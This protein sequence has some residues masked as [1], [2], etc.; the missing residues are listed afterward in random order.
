MLDRHLFGQENA[1][2]VKRLLFFLSL[3]IRVLG[4]AQKLTSV[5]DH[6]LL[7]F[8]FEAKVLGHKS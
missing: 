7:L 3:L 4:Q 6:L 5:M 8:P 1:M 2:K